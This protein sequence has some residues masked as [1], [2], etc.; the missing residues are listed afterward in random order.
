MASCKSCKE[1][2]PPQELTEGFCPECHTPEKM[3]KYERRETDSTAQ[4]SQK[5]LERK[6]LLL[7]DDRGETI[8][9]PTGFS[10]TALFFNFF[11]PFLRG[12]LKH[13]GLFFLVTVF[14]VS[15]NSLWGFLLVSKLLLTLGFTPQASAALFPWI[16]LGSLCV[17]IAFQLYLGVRYNTL[18][19]R[20]LLKQ[21]YRPA[22]ASH[23]ALLDKLGIVASD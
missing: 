18:Y 11:V 5:A 13:A 21:G 8:E 10:W 15:I 1:I 9:A 16:V 23:N 19:I 17:L 7:I 12:D 22:D 3:A 20:S 2:F 6:R 14:L 4:R